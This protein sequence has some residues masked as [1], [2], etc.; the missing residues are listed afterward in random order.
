LPAG[1]GF[2]SNPGALVER[3][4]GLAVHY[5]LP[6]EAAA[7]LGTLLEL[8]AAEQ[9]SLTSVRDQLSAVD[10]HVADSLV[11]LDLEAVRSARAIADLGA[12]G[13]FPGFA[14]AVA[15]PSARVVLVE[16]VQKKCAFLRRATQTAGLGN[17]EVVCARAEGWEAGVGSA[18][19]VTARALAPLPVVLEYAAPLLR[20]GG[21][22]VAWKGRR[23]RDEEARGALAAAELGLAAPGPQ[24]VQ[25]F[26]GAG[27]RYLYLSSKVSATPATFP[28]RAGMARKRPLGGS[29]RA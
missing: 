15:L 2:T 28:R 19:L 4:E 23:D 29:T 1:R 3:L 25:P 13:G 21:S 9:I 22:L 8:L 16:S 17:V 5:G 26:E 14:L 7:T 6:A 27:E 24:R 12:G 20:I 11:A 18:D 10:A